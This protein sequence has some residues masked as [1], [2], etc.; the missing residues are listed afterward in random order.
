[1]TSNPTNDANK[2]REQLLDE[3]TES[4]D[5]ERIP[6]ALARLSFWVP[7]ARMAEFEKAYEQQV[8]PILEK[9]GLVQSGECGR[10]PV[11][12]I[13]SRLFELESPTEVSA[14]EQALHKDATWQQ[15][16]RDLGTVFG[17]T[18]AALQLDNHKPFYDRHFTPQMAAGRA[19]LI[20]YHWGLYR[21]AGRIGSSGRGRRDVPTRCLAEF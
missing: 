14:R 7:A 5:T 8:V 2:S 9:H 3:P 20:H 16:L 19:S 13:F 21:R 10:A 12:S 17:T 1:M 15:V 11:E 18:F 4:P 6:L